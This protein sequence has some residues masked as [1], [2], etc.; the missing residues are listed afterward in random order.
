MTPAKSFTEI[1]AKRG[2][3]VIFTAN[4]QVGLRFEQV[5]ERNHARVI[6]TRGWADPYGPLGEWGRI[7]NSRDYGVLSCNQTT[8]AGGFKIPATDL[9]WVGE[10]GNPSSNASLWARCCDAMDSAQ[11]LEQ[12]GSRVNKWLLGEN[13]L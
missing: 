5:A 13:D 1:L 3:I 8:Y 10:T 4:A 2:R 7:H 11:H 12:I 6:H 9:V